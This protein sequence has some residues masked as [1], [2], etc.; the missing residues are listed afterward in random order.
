[1]EFYNIII[2]RSELF[3][4][5]RYFFYLTLSIGSNSFPTIWRITRIVPIPK[6]AEKGKINNHRPVAILSPP[7]KLF[8]TSIYSRHFHT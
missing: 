6:M 7:A 3:I 1:M 8:E 4:Y 5:I 2:P